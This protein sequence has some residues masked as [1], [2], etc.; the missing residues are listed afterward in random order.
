[1][2][3]VSFLAQQLRLSGALTVYLLSR[4]QNP[5]G[6]GAALWFFRLPPYKATI[7]TGRSFKTAILKEP[8]FNEAVPKLQFWNSNLKIR[9]FARLKA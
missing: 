3:T 2:S 9:S 8:L 6:F 5:V 1:V 7:L 4:F